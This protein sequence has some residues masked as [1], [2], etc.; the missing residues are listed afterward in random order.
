MLAERRTVA[1]LALLRSEP[2]ADSEHQR[3]NDPITL[4]FSRTDLDSEALEVRVSQSVHGPDYDLSNQRG[5][6]FT[7]IPEPALVTVHLDHAPVAGNLARYPGDAL[8][9]FYPEEPLHY[10]SRVYVDVEYA[11]ETLSRFGYR[12]QALPTH[13]GGVVTD[14]F[15][16]P[17]SNIE[18]MLPGLDLATRTDAAGNFE[19]GADDTGGVPIPSGRHALVLNPAQADPAYGVV[20]QWANVQAGRINRLGR[21]ALPRILP[22]EPYVPLAGGERVSLYRGAVELDL[23]DAT[24]RFPDGRERGRAQVQMLLNGQLPHATSRAAVPAFAW[25]LQPTGIEVTGEVS[26]AIDIPAYRGGYA[27]VPPEGTLVAL[28]GYDRTARQLMPIGSGRVEGRRIVSVGPV[29]LTSLDYLTY[30]LVPPAALS[31]LADWES[32]ETRSAAKLHA[33]LQDAIE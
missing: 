19:F 11:G 18:V 32:G 10:G 8:V 27:H 12:V 15:G 24:L 1:P 29:A 33:D 28:V 9:T 14:L 2:A 17:L 23:S 22:D 16:S 21:Q 30:A 3:P 7:D 20:E 5:V 31:A 26:L 6:G 25:H 4:Y 13:V